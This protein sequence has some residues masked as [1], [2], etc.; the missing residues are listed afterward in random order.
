M[1]L[2]SDV[3]FEIGRETARGHPVVR[4]RVTPH[5]LP[6]SICCLPITSKRFELGITPER[7]RELLIHPDD[8]HDLLGEMEGEEGRGVNEL[9]EA[10][11]LPVAQD[12]A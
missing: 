9:R 2:R 5:A 10:F 11:G 8:W 4:I 12:P 7:R 6:G 1:T 3:Q